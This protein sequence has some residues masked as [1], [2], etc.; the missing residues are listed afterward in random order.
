MRQVTARVISNT[1]VMPGIHLLWLQAPEIAYFAQ[2]GQFVMV[3]C[4]DSLNPLLRRPLSIHRVA[5]EGQIALLFDVVGQGTQWLSQRQEGDS[6]DLL[7]PLGKGFSI[8]HNRGKLLLIA[9][10]IGIAPLAFTA[11]KALSEGC[12][13]TLLMGAQNAST[14]YPRSLLPS[15]INLITVTE[16]GS[17]GKKGIVTEFIVDFIDQADQI[18][19]CGPT[20][21]Y[22]AISAQ[23]QLVGK[24][25][26]ASLEI[27]M[28]C[29]RGICYGCTIKTK[30]GLKRVC[31]DGPVFELEEIVWK[32]LGL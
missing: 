10:G 9:G 3:R 15:S 8:H 17:E 21:M 12:S 31:Q 4:G 7:G 25:V 11:E 24:S 20:S 32:E 30:K 29:G 13:V 5:D 26:Q 1:E 6:L 23:N 22:Q 27:M 18:L 28:G 19:A 2:P 16:D 14:L